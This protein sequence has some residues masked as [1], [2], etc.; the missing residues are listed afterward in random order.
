MRNNFRSRRNLDLRNAVDQALICD[1]PSVL[2]EYVDCGN[3]SCKII[4]LML[5]RQRNF[6][7]TA[8]VDYRRTVNFLTNKADF[9]QFMRI[10][11]AILLLCLILNEAF[12]GKIRLRITDYIAA[13][14]EYAALVLGNFQKRIAENIRMIERNR[15]YNADLGFL[16]DIC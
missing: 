10:I 5:A 7:S 14:F 11:L 3:R 16:N 13:L 6:K 4:K 9:A 15:S 12:N 2:L 8:G 1:V